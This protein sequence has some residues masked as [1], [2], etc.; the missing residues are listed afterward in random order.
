MVIDFG[1]GEVT[2]QWPVGT[3]EIVACV[4]SMFFCADQDDTV[5]HLD[6]SS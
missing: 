1:S 4:R 2:E 3:V 6:P 5:G